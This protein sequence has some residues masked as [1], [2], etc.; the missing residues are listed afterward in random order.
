MVECCTG[1]RLSTGVGS[2]LTECRGRSRTFRMVQKQSPAALREADPVS[3]QNGR[4]GAMG[5]MAASV[6][7]AG[8]ARSGLVNPG[9]Y[10]APST[11][12][13]GIHY[14]SVSKG[15]LRSKPRTI[16]VDQ[17]RQVP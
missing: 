4:Q 15:G 16:P 12:Q 3:G 7:S 1:I 11:M 14:P 9:G 10:S 2:T 13:T 8:I 17:P 6:G 5:I